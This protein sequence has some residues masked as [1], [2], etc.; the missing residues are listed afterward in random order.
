VSG[1][2]LKEVFALYDK[3][4]V[5]FNTAA[6]CDELRRRLFSLDGDGTKEPVV[7]EELISGLW[8]LQ[9]IVYVR[10]VISVQ[11]SMKSI[12]FPENG[13][14]FSLRQSKHSISF[15]DSIGSE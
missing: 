15:F 11:I 8:Q 6:L 7:V 13:T 3:T 10:A 12:E 2:D 9:D 1:G 5:V 14:F 4:V